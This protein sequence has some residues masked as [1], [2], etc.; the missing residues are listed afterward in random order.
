MEIARTGS[1]QDNERVPADVRE[2]FRTAMDID[3]EW[4]VRMQAAFQKHVDNAVSKTINLPRSAGIDDVRRAFLLA[5]DLG[6]KG[7]TVFR[8]GSR[9]QQV[10][11]LSGEDR[12]EDGE[13]TATCGSA[14]SSPA[15]ARLS[16]ARSRYSPHNQAFF[17]LPKRGLR[18]SRR[19]MMPG[20]RRAF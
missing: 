2:L 12:G 11:Y 5:W 9:K 19:I 16:T 17:T 13:A 18:Q 10:L 8:Y 7:I 6:C 1:V 4:H 14:P 15:A 3:P 20:W